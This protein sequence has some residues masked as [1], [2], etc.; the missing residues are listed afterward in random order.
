VATIGQL[1]FLRENRDLLADPVLLVGSKMYEYDAGDLRTMLAELGLRDVTGV[2]IEAGDGVDEVVDITD[3]GDFL[4]R[5]RDRFATVVCM[6]ILTHVPNPFVAGDNV[7]SLVRP[8]GTVV[9]SE[10]VVRK[11]SRM[12]ADNWRFT[13]TGTKLV[14]SRLEFHDARARMGYTRD[15][16]G[17]LFPVPDQLPAVTDERHPDETSLGYLVRRVHRRFLARGVFQMSRLLPESTLYTIASRP[18]A[19]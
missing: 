6:E 1:N 15:R 13:P 2:D 14:H 4:D 9:L 11:L 12:P 3:P 7:A 18:E 10:V 8:G 19:G 5:N 17:G 16:A